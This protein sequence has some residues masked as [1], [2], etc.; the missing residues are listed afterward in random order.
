MLCVFAFV[1]QLVVFLVN[2]SAS[3]TESKQLKCHLSLRSKDIV[4]LLILSEWKFYD[5]IC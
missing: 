3:S 1:S 4:E 2:C 5:F